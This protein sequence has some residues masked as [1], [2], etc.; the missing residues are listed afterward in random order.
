MTAEHD[1]T[2]RLRCCSTTSM[3]ALSCLV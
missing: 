2:K 1:A 3:T